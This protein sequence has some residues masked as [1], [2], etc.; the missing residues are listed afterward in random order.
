LYSQLPAC[1]LSTPAT[2]HLLGHHPTIQEQVAADDTGPAELARAAVYE[3]MRLY[4]PAYVT[5]RRA[6]TDVD[7]T[8]H[9]VTAGT[10]VVVSPWI[11]HR[12]PAFWPEPD[13]F[14]PHRFIGRQ[15]RPRYAYLPFG[16]GP[17][18]CI[19]EHFALLEATTLLQTLLARYRLVSLD[20]Q[21]TLAPLIALR[22]GTI[23]TGQ[24]HPALTNSPTLAFL[25]PAARC[26]AG[27]SR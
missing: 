16:G 19:G 12:H 9:L 4:P 1:S 25:T 21:P 6:T 23:R 11:T 10:I 20:D 3:G 15:D 14:D 27:T 24:A 26:G 18:S 5:Q 8:G 7:I 2:L 22:P 17:R 13:R